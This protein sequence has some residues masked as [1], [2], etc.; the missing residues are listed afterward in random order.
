MI[1]E[2]PIYVVAET[3]GTGEIVKGRLVILD[4]E[5]VEISPLPCVYTKAEEGINFF[6]I[7][8]IYKTITKEEV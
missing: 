1:E 4:G 7:R 5:S 3:A 6:V 2:E 8:K